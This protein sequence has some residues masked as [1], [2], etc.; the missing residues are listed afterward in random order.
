MPGRKIV[1]MLSLGAVLVLPA[2]ANAEY[3]HWGSEVTGVSASSLWQ[4][5]YLEATID[6]S[7]RSRHLKRI[8][9]RRRYFCCYRL[10]CLQLATTARRLRCIRT[11]C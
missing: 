5:E 3:L 4:V 11:S 7:L 9:V 10:L 8:S 2:A 6:A 1:M